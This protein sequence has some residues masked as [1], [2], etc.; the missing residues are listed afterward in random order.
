MR[1][2]G[3]TKKKIPEEMTDPR[4][5]KEEIKKIRAKRKGGNKTLG[6][7]RWKNLTPA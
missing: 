3:G 4:A 5:K 6:E 2:G 1:G 7:E